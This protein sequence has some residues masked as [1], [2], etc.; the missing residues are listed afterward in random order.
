MYEKIVLIFLLLGNI[1]A[2]IAII[3]IFIF[4]KLNRAIFE[5]FRG[6]TAGGKIIGFSIMVGIL[7]ILFFIIYCFKKNKNKKFLIIAILL[8]LF[9]FITLSIL[10][11]YV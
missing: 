3:N 2:T 5:F 6:G 1:G 4:F 8:I 7:G 10:G 9:F 11:M